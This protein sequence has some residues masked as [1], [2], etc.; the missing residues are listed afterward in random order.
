MLRNATKS[1]TFFSDDQ[2]RLELDP[3]CLLVN[4]GENVKPEEE[5][6]A[7]AISDYVNASVLPGQAP[8][9][10]LK[11]P[12]K[13]HNITYLAAQAQNACSLCV[14]WRAIWDSK[15]QIIVMLTK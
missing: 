6:S 8:V 9:V 3:P 4:P 12:Q 1:V 11:G 2:N 13:N 14:F 5:L 7:K 15:T 10:P